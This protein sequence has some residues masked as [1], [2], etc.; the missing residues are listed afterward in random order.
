LGRNLSLAP[1]RVQPRD[2][3]TSLIDGLCDQ[4]LSSNIFQ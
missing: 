4:P 3:L 1:C 2:R